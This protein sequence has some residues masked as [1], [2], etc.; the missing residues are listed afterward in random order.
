MTTDR[1][2]SS[3]SAASAASGV[4]SA[5]AAFVEIQHSEHWQLLLVEAVA[6]T[7]KM[8]SGVRPGV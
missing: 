4:A 7:V 8:G 3:N 6:Q 5:S 2:N 1:S